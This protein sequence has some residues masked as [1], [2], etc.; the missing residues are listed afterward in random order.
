MK[1]DLGIYEEGYKSKGAEYDKMKAVYW[2]C[3]EAGIPV[4]DQ[5]RIYFNDKEPSDSEFVPTELGDA[6][7]YSD[8][9]SEH[10][11]TSEK[12]TIYLKALPKDVEIISFDIHA[13]LVD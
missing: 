10:G 2:A 13:K 3:V 11:K 1:I 9:E 7:I 8:N 5:V 6:V 12:V 4:P